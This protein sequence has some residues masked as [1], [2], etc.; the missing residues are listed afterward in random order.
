MFES[1]LVMSTLQPDDNDA[2]ARSME[3]TSNE[4]RNLNISATS[5]TNRSIDNSNGGLSI[6][7]KR[8]RIVSQPDEP[9]VA[10]CNKV[11][12]EDLFQFDKDLA[13]EILSKRRKT[14]MAPSTNSGSSIVPNVPNVESVIPYPGLPPTGEDEEVAVLF[15]DESESISLLNDDE[16][17]N[18]IALGCSA[19]NM[20]Q[21]KGRDHRAILGT[22]FDR[23]RYSPSTQRSKE[24]WAEC[25]DEE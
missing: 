23:C 18:E 7:G 9:E 24:I 22:L 3:Q 13:S 2:S 1:N 4:V 16:V 25:S 19:R 21:R 12:S 8:N 17:A 15:V 10:R 6:L 14:Q 20:P 5:T 11:V